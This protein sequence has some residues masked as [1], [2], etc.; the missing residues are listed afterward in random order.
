MI[1]NK[2]IVSQAE[3]ARMLQVSRAYVNQLVTLNK[4]TSIII[5]GRKLVLIDNKFESL[6]K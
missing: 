3:A 4:L 1:D 5:A 6:K 2:K